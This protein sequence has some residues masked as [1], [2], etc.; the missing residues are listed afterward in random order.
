[1]WTLVG[2]TVSVSV[3]SLAVD[4]G[5]GGWAVVCSWP[6]GP[7][8]P[9]SFDGLPALPAV[10]FVGADGAMFTGVAALSWAE[11]APDSL[12][13]APTAWLGAVSVSVSGR[14]IDPVDVVAVLW[15]RVLAE[16]LSV[17]GVAV[18][19]VSVA[20]PP[21]WGPRRRGLL[22]AAAQRAGVDVSVFVPAPV[23]AAVHASRCGDV[24]VPP[25]GVLAV[26]D[27]GAGGCTGSV[28]LRESELGWQ[29]LSTA[30][31]AAGGGDRLDEALLLRLRPAGT[32]G[33][34]AVAAVRMAKEALTYAAEVPLVLDGVP[35]VLTRTVLD[36]VAAPV[37]ASA[38]D[39]MRRA[40]DAA[41]VVAADVTGVV[42]VGGGASLP[43]L[44]AELAAG[45][46]R[47]VVTP[48]R[49][50]E[51]AVLGV[52]YAFRTGPEPGEVGWAAVPP[53][54]RGFW[55]LLTVLASVAGSLVLLAHVV[56][57]VDIGYRDSSRYFVNY[58]FFNSG[59]Y[60]VACALAVVAAMSVARVVA[61]AHS[62]RATTLPPL[63]ARPRP[64]RAFVSSALAGVAVAGVYGMVARVFLPAGTP[65]FLGFGI[66]IAVPLAVTALWFAAITNR[67]GYL[68]GVA[69][70]QLR[71]PAAGVVL[72]TVG[73][74]LMQD[75]S[76]APSGSVREVFGFHGGGA[77]VGAAC[78]WTLTRSWLPRL[79]TVVFL[80]AAGALA[81]DFANRVTFGYAYVG[82]LYVWWFAAAA[83]TTGQA[84]PN[85]WT[86]T[87]TRLR[88]LA[89]PPTS[90]AG[91]DGGNGL[92]GGPGNPPAR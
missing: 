19:A 32:S 64:A 54:D 33:V 50:R 63:A 73:M 1:V 80:V 58:V 74:V 16:A 10:V 57:T 78:G 38:V 13:W 89:S 37:V 27:V 29:V 76:I 25:G 34:A 17:T 12:V 23:A 61:L 75:A 49:P 44:A 83:A 42:C 41:D 82:C 92:V 70:N 69:Y 60:A 24:V 2:H 55:Q 68:G 90:T 26:C 65:G 40:V 85:W 47:P 72:A 56:T 43:G 21:V 81:A 88:A 51:A 15:R 91:V 52:G 4:I 8:M 48:A 45:C 7:M 35:L 31:V 3:I 62:Q 30:T 59:E 5:S 11:T 87:R 39:V 86:S 36:Q 67:L 46:G 77:L 71:L 20:V 84:F 28:L 18:G 14:D 6:S 9:L 22:R 66:R 79:F 53:P